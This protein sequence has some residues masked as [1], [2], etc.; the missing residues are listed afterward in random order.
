MGQ[1]W[2]KR[3]CNGIITEKGKQL[4]EASKGTGNKLEVLS[5]GWGYWD[6]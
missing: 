4:R 6:L 2:D 5:G 1:D 3:D